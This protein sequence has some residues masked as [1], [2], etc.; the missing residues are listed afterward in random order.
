MILE[1][2]VNLIKNEELRSQVQSVVVE[3]EEYFREYPVSI[4]GKY[5]KHEPTM[6]IH[7]K[8]TVFFSYLM[9]DE[10]DLSAQDSDILIAA[11]ILHDIGKSEYCCKGPKPGNQL[12][13]GTGWSI[14]RGNN[15]HS[16][17]GGKMI[18]EA[19]IKDGDVI[20]RIV[21]RH[22][23]HWDKQSPQPESLLEYILC[24]ADYMA[25]REEIIIKE[26]T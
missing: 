16:M 13:E 8:R 23:C 1:K 9:C 20:A 3:H 14:K 18:R 24:M 10:F 12:Y 15:N 4:S 22:M 19:G 7:V 17:T 21:E 2:E 6:D 26:K 25:S 5:H 11:A